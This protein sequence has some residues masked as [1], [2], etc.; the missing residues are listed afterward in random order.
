MV[1]SVRTRICFFVSLCMLLCLQD[2]TFSKFSR[3]QD[4]GQED[5][6]QEE[7]GQED[8]GPDRDVDQPA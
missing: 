4:G 6:G 8:G 1:E 3:V 2:V 5:E 7:E